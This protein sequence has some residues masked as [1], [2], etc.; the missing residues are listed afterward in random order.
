MNQSKP[1][2][3]Q[4]VTLLLL[5]ALYWYFNQGPLN[6]S[7]S[8]ATVQNQVQALEQYFQNRTSKKM[9]QITG[10][11]IKLLSDDLIEPRHQ[12]FIVKTSNRMSLLVTHNIDLAPRINSLNEGDEVLI[13]GQYEWNDKGGIL[14]WT[15]H[16]PKN[17]RAGG[18]IIHNGKKYE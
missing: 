8:A 9:I 18:W 17:R 16:D 15:H 1:K 2:V 13:Y 11:V 10:T 6:K 3:I 4:I 7:N 5:G 14:H 12:K